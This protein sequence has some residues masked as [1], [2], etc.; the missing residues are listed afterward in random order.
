MPIIDLKATSNNIKSL[1]KNSGLKVK[2]IANIFGFASPYP[3]YK[4]QNGESLPTLDNL[5]ILANLLNVTMDDLII[6]KLI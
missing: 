6:V 3:I 2:D 4:W 5:V 1:I